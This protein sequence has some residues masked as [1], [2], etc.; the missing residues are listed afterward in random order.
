MQPAIFVL[1]KKR[2]TT[3][4]NWA[5]FGRQ[6]IH[7]YYYYMEDHRSGIAE[8]ATRAIQSCRPSLLTKAPCFGQNEMAGCILRQSSWKIST[9]TRAERA[10]R[11]SL[12]QNSFCEKATGL[13]AKPFSQRSS[14]IRNHLNVEHAILADLMKINFSLLIDATNICV[15]HDFLTFWRISSFSLVAEHTW[16]CLSCKLFFSQ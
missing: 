6:L 5:Y 7:Y 12:L 2:R 3:V 14:L 4:K 11:E 9:D 8:S 15:V 1:R 13:R 16:R 10:E